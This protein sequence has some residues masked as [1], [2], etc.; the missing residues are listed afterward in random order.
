MVFVPK[1]QSSATLPS[2]IESQTD[3]PTDTHHFDDDPHGYAAEEAEDDHFFYHGYDDD[4]CYDD[5]KYYEN[6]NDTGG[7]PYALCFDIP[8]ADIYCWSPTTHTHE[9]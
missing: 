5:D 2:L 6:H 8:D 9:R 1:E 3:A 4:D 7:D